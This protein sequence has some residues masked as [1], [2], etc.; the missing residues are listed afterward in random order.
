MPLLVR[1]RLLN[2]LGK[3]FVFATHSG[4]MFNCCCVIVFR[5]SVMI[6]NYAFGIVL[7]DDL[8]CRMIE[9]KNF[10]SLH[11]GGYEEKLCFIPWRQLRHQLN[12]QIMSSL[13]DCGSWQSVQ[14][15]VWPSIQQ[16][17]HTPTLKVETNINDNLK[18]T[19]T[20]LLLELLLLLL[21]PVISNH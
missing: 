6:L 20:S 13:L 2:L 8:W 12:S 14:S 1:I 18:A 9:P 17:L 5:M 11:L 19:D 10:G 7:S 3:S 16:K 15:M 4:I 21:L